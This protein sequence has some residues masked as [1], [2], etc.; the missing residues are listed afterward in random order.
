MTKELFAGRYELLDEAPAGA[1]GRLFEARDTT[2]ERRVAVKVFKSPLPPGAAERGDLDDVFGRAQKA[3][4]PHVLGYYE[5]SLDEGYLVREWVHGFSLL[6]LLRR[7]REIPAEE[8]VSLLDGIAGAID[9]VAAQGLG[10]GGDFLVRLFAGFGRDV[11]HAQLVRWR[12]EPVPKW[13]DFQVKLNPL[14]I[15]NFLPTGDDDAMNT[16]VNVRP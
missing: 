9:F 4:H 6:E 7:R 5:L 1:G 11:T 10:P 16:M 3:A 14:S 13:P 8:A 2:N 15:A 12:G